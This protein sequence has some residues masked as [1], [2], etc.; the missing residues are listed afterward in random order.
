[1]AKALK[2]MKKSILRGTIF[3]IL[4]LCVVL[5]AVQYKS[6]KTMLYDQY[7]SSI[8]SVLNYVAEEIDVDDLAQCIRTGL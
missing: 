6:S 7:A 8:G 1:M 4:V 3:F 2:P 5:S